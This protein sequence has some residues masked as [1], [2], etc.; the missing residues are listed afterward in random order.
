MD[1]TILQTRKMPDYVTKSDFFTFKLKIEKAYEVVSNGNWCV[2]FISCKKN[3]LL[4]KVTLDMMNAYWEQYDFLVD[5]LWIDY[6]WITASERIPAIKKMLLDVPCSNP[7]LFSLRDLM[8]KCTYEE[9][10]QRTGHED[11]AFYKMSYKGT[12]GIPLRDG[13]GHTTLLGRIIENN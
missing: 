1:A 11:T 9:Y 5:Y 4:M 3:N 10:K 6:L 12:K 7:N 13:S 8:A 2:F